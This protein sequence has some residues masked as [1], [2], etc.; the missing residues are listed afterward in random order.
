MGGFEFKKDTHRLL[1]V[2]Q[3]SLCA[4]LSDHSSLVKSGF[5]DHKE[6]LKNIYGKVKKKVRQKQR[7]NPAKSHI[8]NR[9]S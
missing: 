1:A 5:V 7:D 3:L 2:A 4:L 6:Y 9:S 8:I